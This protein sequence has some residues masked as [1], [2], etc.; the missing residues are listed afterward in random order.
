MAPSFEATL[1]LPPPPRFIQ[2]EPWE[3]AEL[4]Q[5]LAQYSWPKA[6]VSP[7][8]ASLNQPPAPQW[9]LPQAKPQ[10][11]GTSG[12]RP[13]T[14]EEAHYV[15]AQYAMGLTP[16]SWTS[17]KKPLMKLTVNPFFSKLNNGFL[18]VGLPIFDFTCRTIPL[19]K[20]SKLTGLK[21][22]VPLLRFALATIPAAIAGS[23][24]GN[25]F[26]HKAIQRNQAIVEYLQNHAPGTTWGDVMNDPSVSPRDFS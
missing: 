15:K 7:S 20:L 24:A 13:L 16:I 19:D 14:P 23:L 4:Q 26:K 11:P 18:L 10:Q 22:G 12:K 3:Q 17:K 2:L 21:K 6:P 8:A 1:Q 9:Q 5:Q 25:W